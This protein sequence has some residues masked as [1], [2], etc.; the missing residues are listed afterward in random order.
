M[1]ASV[2]TIVVTAGESFAQSTESWMTALPD[3][4][5]LS[6]M[7]IPGT[8]DTCALLGGDLFECQTMPLMDQ[9]N[10]GIRFIDIRCR[11]IGDVFA[12]H[13]DRVY[14]GIE[15]GE[16]VRDVCLRF[17]EEHPGE[18]II[19]SV[20]EEYQP[21]HNT[22]SFEATFDWYL[23]GNRNRWY[24]GNTVPALGDVRGK[25]VLFRRFSATAPVLGIDA[26]RWPD[27]VTFAINNSA[28][29]KVQDEYVVPTV[30]AIPKK[31]D[32]IKVLLDE[33]G[34]ATDDRWYV[35]FSSGTSGGAGAYPYTVAKGSPGITGEND[36]LH[37]YLST[38][39]AGKV[40]TILMDFPEYPDNLLIAQ[41]IG[42]N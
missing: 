12:I 19:M 22:R 31:W 24:L 2:W 35:N 16:G 8:H 36:H 11:H 29:L 14:Q 30:F 9:L 34:S 33:A 42:L 18:C 4:R 39:P 25:I 5:L 15:F 13:H 10:A 23:E 26:S 7:S 3:T 1:V 32:K 37:V 27:D 6:Q 28:H 17:L 20:K 38:P 40:G 21:A 41:L